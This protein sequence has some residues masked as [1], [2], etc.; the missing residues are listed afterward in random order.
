M[1]LENIYY[2]G[3]TIAVVAI[4]GSLIA[5]I[6]Q[7]RHAN[8]LA[9][10]A[11]AFSQTEGL[12]NIQRTIVE[13]P[14]LVGVLHRGN[15]GLS[16]L[17]DEERILFISF[18]TYALRVWEGLHRQ[19]IDGHL[20]EALWRAHCRHLRDFQNLAGTKEVWSIKRHIYSKSFRE[21]FDRNVD[22]DSAKNLFELYTPKDTLR[23]VDEKT[24]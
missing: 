4:L 12:Q 16:L 24:P 8:K 3:Q 14:G 5:L 11:A 7:M 6:I 15:S 9:R 13:T 22:A 17:D 2:I 18:H 20:D 19:F 21:F 10:R 1:S 23:Q